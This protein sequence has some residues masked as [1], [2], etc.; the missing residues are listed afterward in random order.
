MFFKPCLM[1]RLPQLWRGAQRGFFRAKPHFLSFGTPIRKRC[2]AFRA[3]HGLTAF[4]V[5]YHYTLLYN[6]ADPGHCKEA[7]G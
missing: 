3:L 1:L 5:A 2:R 6:A 4:P 7:G